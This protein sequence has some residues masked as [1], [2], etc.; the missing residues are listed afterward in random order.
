MLSSLSL[1]ALKQR[2]EPL[3]LGGYGGTPAQGGLLEPPVLP[4]S[5]SVLVFGEEERAGL[6]APNR[7]CRPP[8]APEAAVHPVSDRNAFRYHFLR[9]NNT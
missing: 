7:A 1:Q 9:W 4:S 8:G 3:L 2:S 6:R 5:V